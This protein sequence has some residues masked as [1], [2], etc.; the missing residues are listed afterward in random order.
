MITTDLTGEAHVSFGGDTF[1]SGGEVGGSGHQR[2]A[3]T[4]DALPYLASWVRN[5]DKQCVVRWKVD[6]ST[7]GGLS[8]RNTQGYRQFILVQ[9]SKPYVHHMLFFVLGMLEREFLQLRNRERVVED[10]AV[11]L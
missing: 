1:G 2:V 11:L 9:A 7:S 3:I 6:V 4:Y 5:H 10:S 8:T